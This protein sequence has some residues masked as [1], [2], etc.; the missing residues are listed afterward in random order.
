MENL[1]LAAFPDADSGFTDLIAT[2]NHEMT[3]SQISPFCDG[4]ISPQEKDRAFLF[5]FAG[6]SIVMPLVR[7]RLTRT[8]PDKYWNHSSVITK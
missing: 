8:A 4:K 3:S 7:T 1:P 2:A 5:A 6:E